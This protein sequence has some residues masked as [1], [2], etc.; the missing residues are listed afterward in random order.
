MDNLNN[1]NDFDVIIIGAGVAGFT[2][3]IYAS[4]ERH[5][6]LI[7]ERGKTGGLASTTHWM[8]NYPGFPSGI[9]GRDLTDLFR[10]QAEKFGAEIREFIDV[11]SLEKLSNGKISVHTT[12]EE[13]N[14]PVVIIATGSLP[15]RLGIPGE[16][17]FYGRGVSYCA[18]CD[19][20]FFRDLD[21]AIVGCGNSGLQE[22]QVLLEL[23]KTVTFIEYFESIPGERILF[24]RIDKAENSRFLP[25]HK[26]L[27]IEG[28]QFLERVIAE[29]RATNK[30]IEIPV[31]GVFIYAGYK[32]N[33]DFVKDFVTLDERGYI[34]TDDAMQTSIEGVFA[35]GDV[36]KKLIQ[37]VTVAT[38]DGTIAAIHAGKYLRNS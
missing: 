33:S 36:R 37:Q 28:E 9:S 20:A 30:E 7:L 3:A 26:V 34:I 35:A 19:G 27:R 31:A 11:K 10:A 15:R 29:N 8:E 16:M 5:R 18:T 23:C 12:E 13:L 6:T 1:N 2:A 38:S 14:A 25:N 4:R 22:G 32:P 24:E 17:E 21:V